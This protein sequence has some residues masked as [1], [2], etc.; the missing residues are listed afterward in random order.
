[1]EISR[2]AQEKLARAVGGHGSATVVG[3]SGDTVG[4]PGTDGPPEDATTVSRV[5]RIVEEVSGV[6]YEEISADSDLSAD[7][8]LSSLALIEVSIRIEDTLRVR[9]DEADIW[10]AH[11]VADLVAA[12]DG[13]DAESAPATA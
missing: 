11:T 10:A 13:V 9:L 12:V 3:S 5:T 7:L 4:N 6:P 1:M 2:E 8:D